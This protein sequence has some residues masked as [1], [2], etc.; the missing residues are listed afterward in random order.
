[1]ECKLEGTVDYLQFVES[2]LDAAKQNE[3]PQDKSPKQQEEYYLG[4]P[5]Y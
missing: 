3:E 2:T 1:M 4:I 5:I